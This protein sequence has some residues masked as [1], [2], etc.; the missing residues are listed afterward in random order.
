MATSCQVM[1]T[2]C[3]VMDICCQVM[4]TSCRVIA[5]SCQVLATSCQVMA[6][7]CQ[8]MATSCQVMATCCSRSWL[9]AFRS[10][11]PAARSW[12]P[13]VRSWLPAA[14]SWLPV[15]ASVRVSLAPP[16]FWPPP[17]TSTILKEAVQRNCLFCLFAKIKTLTAAILISISC[18]HLPSIS[19]LMISKDMVGTILVRITQQLE[20]WSENMWHYTNFSGGYQKT[21]FMDSI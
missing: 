10:W 12:L 3:H 1:A 15:P 7:S 17:T 2:S 11:L 8:V 14:R 19:P 18:F 13:A 4:A 21:F 20:T 5:T 16:S 6:T 9:P